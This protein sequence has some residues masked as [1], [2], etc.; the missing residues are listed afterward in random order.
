MRTGPGFLAVAVAAIALVLPACGAAE[1]GPPPNVFLEYARS[2]E[3]KN[4][5]FPTDTSGEDRL[6]NFAAHYTPEQLQTRLLSA[7]PCAESEECRPNARVKQAWHDF[8]G[9][10]GELFG[11]SV[12]AR[13]EDGSLELVTLYVA[14]KADGA[15]LVI[16]SKGGTYSGLE[17]FRDNN[18]LFGTGDWML[19]P[20][21]LTAVP[22]EG[23]IVTVTGQ[24]PARWQPWVFGGSGAVVVLAGTAVA[25]RRLRDRRADPAVG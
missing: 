15:T 18:D 10:D 7:F 23:E 3:V 22:G 4:D 25:L 1:P 14:R 19:A 17:D 6:A 9:Q 24:L 16:D 12:V 11:R 5:R 20:R 8:A 21:D 13:Y 2:G